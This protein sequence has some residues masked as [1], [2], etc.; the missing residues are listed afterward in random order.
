MRLFGIGIVCSL[1]LALIGCKTVGKAPPPT[2]IQIDSLSVFTTSFEGRP[3][4]YADITGHLSSGS[5][6]PVE[7]RQWRQGY[8]LYIEFNEQTPAGVVGQTA[9]VPI[10]RRI[11]IEITGLAPGVYIVNVNGKE[12]HL[13]IDGLGHRPAVDRGQFL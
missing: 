8:R 9:L 1:G 7:P 11:P 10:Q 2:P 4:A 13:E 12:E 6:Q 5:A 3:E